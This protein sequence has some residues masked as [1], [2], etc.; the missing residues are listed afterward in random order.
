M[1]PKCVYPWRDVATRD[2]NDEW[3][4]KGTD[5]WMSPDIAPQLWNRNDL[6]LNQCRL[7]FGEV[8]E[9]LDTFIEA[10]QLIQAEALKTFC[11][12]FRTRKFRRFNGLI[13]WNL[14]DGWPIVSDAVVDWFGVRKKAYFAL[15]N[16]Q[17]DQLVCV[18]DSGEVWAVNDNLAPVGGHATVTDAASG[19]LLLDADWELGPN[20]AERIGKVEWEGQGVLD[21]AYAVGEKQFRN[22]YLY[23]DPPFRRDYIIAL[24]FNYMV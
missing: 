10:S 8:S 6:M 22:W 3:R 18:I 7:M 17:R 19:H 9:D 14:R 13:W 11:E 24:L 4:I 12:L 1:T 5:C 23:G 21:I 16:A 15:K 20:A 2:W